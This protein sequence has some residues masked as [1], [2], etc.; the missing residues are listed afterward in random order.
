MTA[1]LGHGEEVMAATPLHVP[2]GDT[3]EGKAATLEWRVQ[4]WHCAPRKYLLL[5]SPP[6]CVLVRVWT[7][8]RQEPRAHRRHCYHSCGADGG[9]ARW[10][11][12]GGGMVEVEIVAAAAL[13]LVLHV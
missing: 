5:L 6:I 11:A 4:P 2:C 9:V 3:P 1:Q 8:G 7:E 10:K 12:D 13:Y